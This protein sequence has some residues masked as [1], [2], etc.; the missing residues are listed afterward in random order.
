MINRRQE[1]YMIFYRELKRRRAHGENKSVE[2]FHEGG[3]KFFVGRD[4][5]S[6]HFS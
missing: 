5:L 2:V 3:L 6:F 4:G 1:V